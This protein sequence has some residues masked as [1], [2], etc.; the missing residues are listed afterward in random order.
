MSGT[1]EIPQPT[2]DQIEYLRGL[3]KGAYDGSAKCEACGAPMRFHIIGG[4]GPYHP[5]PLKQAIYGDEVYALAELFLSDCS[6][7]RVK[8][9][10]HLL[11][12]DIQR[13]IDTFIE[14]EENLKE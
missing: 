12:T 3:Q 9:L 5:N 11:A 8:S 2:R 4:P 13:T 7:P 6:S 10:K 1:I 14:Y